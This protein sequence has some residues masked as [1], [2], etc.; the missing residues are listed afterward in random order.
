MLFQYLDSILLSIDLRA[1]ICV[2]IDEV[3]EEGRNGDVV[4]A[5]GV[6]VGVDAEVEVD[7]NHRIMNDPAA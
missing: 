2:I 7:G 4:I 6:G 3:I 1:Q 5:G